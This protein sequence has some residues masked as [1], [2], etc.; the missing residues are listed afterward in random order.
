MLLLLICFCTV[1]H[2]L[3]RA[4]K[5]LLSQDN[6]EY[7]DNILSRLPFIIITQYKAFKFILISVKFHIQTI[8]TLQSQPDSVHII[9][10]HRIDN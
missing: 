4:E 10:R 8:K 2:A 1:I 3:I 6:F 9:L 5:F 7:P